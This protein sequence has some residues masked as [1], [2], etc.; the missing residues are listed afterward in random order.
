M[1]LAYASAARSAQLGRQVGAAIATPEGD[2]L[3]VGMNEVPS[4]RGGVYWE[5]DADDSRDHKREI[6]SNAEQRGF[7][8]ESICAKLTT[9][10]ISPAAI[11]ELV[12]RSMRRKRAG[13]KFQMT[14]EEVRLELD[15]PEQ[16]SVIDCG[17]AYSLLNQAIS[18]RSPS[19][20]EQF[21]ARWMQFSPV[22]GSE[23][24][25]AGATCT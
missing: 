14:A 21:M 9:D 22:H 7:I 17:L 4:A 2:V 20:G 24:A 5:G 19:M 25:S 18:G 6:D 23:F 13:A 8:V 12:N 11:S 10:V 15:H 1:F 16:P 3:A